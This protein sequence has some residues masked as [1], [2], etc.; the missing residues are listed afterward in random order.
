ML[1]TNELQRV[2]TPNFLH[3]ISKKAKTFDFTVRGVAALGS[4]RHV[5]THNFH[6]I[7]R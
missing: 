1:M 5:P 3:E 7:L 6:N 4:S 2:L